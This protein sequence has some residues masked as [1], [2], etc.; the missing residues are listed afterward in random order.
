[1]NV[2]NDKCLI[3][4]LKHNILRSFNVTNCGFS[5]F[6]QSENV[7][8]KKFATLPYTL[9]IIKMYTA[10]FKIY[11]VKYKTYTTLSNAV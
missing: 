7:E 11:T 2:P 8:V 6:S 3:K 10:I 9:K 5:M 4:T 1:M